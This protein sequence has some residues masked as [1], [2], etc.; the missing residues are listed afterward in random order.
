MIAETFGDLLR[1]PAHWAFEGVTDVV[2]GMVIG[3]IVW[4]RIRAHI[5]RDTRD[6]D[7]AVTQHF[8]EYL[9]QLNGRDATNE[10]HQG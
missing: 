10:L 7:R 6:V 5:H 3:G 9:E 1:D 8:H 4:P 2:F